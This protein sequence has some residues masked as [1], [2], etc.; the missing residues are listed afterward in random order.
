MENCRGPA[1]RPSSM[2]GGVALQLGAVVSEAMWLKPIEILSKSKDICIDYDRCGVFED[3]L[4]IAFSWSVI[5]DT[6]TSIKLFGYALAFLAVS[7][8]NNTKLQ[9][10]RAKELQKKSAQDEEDGR[11]LEERDEDGMG[12]KNDEQS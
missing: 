12:R 1:G 9:D 11:R 7:Y 6:V 10:M 8:H 3:W 5:K 4:L 2:P